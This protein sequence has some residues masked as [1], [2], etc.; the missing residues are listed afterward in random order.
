M[1]IDPAL[2]AGMELSSIPSAWLI[3]GEG[4]TR[5]KV[6]GK[7]VD[8]LVYVMFWECGSA[9]FNWFYDSDEFSIFIDGDAYLM[10]RNGRERHFKQGDM[11]LFHA[12]SSCEWRVPDHV[13]KV[14]ILRSSLPWP[15][16][17]AARAWLKLF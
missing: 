10:G 11:A 14:S 8:R 4:L 9:R 16:A 6:L 17:F 5:S 2:S 7:T 13:K 12:G 3:S 1:N 15:V